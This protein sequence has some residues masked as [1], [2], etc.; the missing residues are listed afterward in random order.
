MITD[1]M[2]NRLVFSPSRGI[3]LFLKGLNPRNIGY[4]KTENGV[5]NYYKPEKEKDIFLKTNAWSI[6]YELFKYFDGTIIIT[7]SKRTYTITK[8]DALKYGEFLWFK[9]QGLEK[10]IYIPLKCFA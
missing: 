4:L 7:T 8:H 9:E 10:K 5:T 2:N 1:E 6:C 3:T